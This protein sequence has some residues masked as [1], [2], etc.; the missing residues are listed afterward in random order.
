MLLELTMI[1][2]SYMNI[3]NC[4]ECNKVIEYQSIYTFKN[5][6][7]KNSYCKVCTAKRTSVINQSMGKLKGTNHPMFGKK[8]TLATREKISTN[9][10][11]VS[12]KNNPMIGKSVYSCWIEKYGVDIANQKL[13][14]LKEKRSVNSTGKNN[15]MYGKPAPIG[16]GNGWSGWYKGW[17]FRSLLE[18]SY[19]IKVIERFNIPWVSAESKQY[20]IKYNDIKGNEK[21]YFPDFILADKYIIECKPKKLQNTETVKL[22]KD[23]AINICKNKKLIYKMRSVKVVTYQI[24]KQ[25]IDD[26][27]LRLIQKYQDKFNKIIKKLKL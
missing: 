17:Y 27:E 5:A 14:N 22:K 4:P 7:K 23:A 12:G 18:L 19:M 15:N 26:G 2:I 20:A 3:R 1:F 10:A 25:L 13:L 8:H 21:T 6:I 16:A 24:L 11:D 9:H